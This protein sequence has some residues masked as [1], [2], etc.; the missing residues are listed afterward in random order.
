M[1]AEKPMTITREE[2]I[3]RIQVAL[4]NV[5]DGLPPVVTIHAATPAIEFHDVPE[6]RVV[7][8]FTLDVLMDKTWS[9]K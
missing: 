6:G 5:F 2:Y 1:N 4:A 8:K 3:K 7:V 9:D